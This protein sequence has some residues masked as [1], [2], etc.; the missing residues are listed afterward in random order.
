MEIMIF[1][2]V[3]PPKCTR[4]PP[5]PKKKRKPPGSPVLSYLLHSVS[6]SSAKSVVIRS[7]LI[8]RPSLE[9]SGLPLLSSQ[10]SSGPAALSYPHKAWRILSVRSAFSPYLKKRAPSSTRRLK[11]YPPPPTHTHCLDVQMYTPQISPQLP[12]SRS[13][14]GAQDAMHQRDTKTSKS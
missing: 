2:R 12:R 5:P 1:N 6:D 11:P 7:A 10:V 4:P 3:L 9:L 13:L 8:H 14:G